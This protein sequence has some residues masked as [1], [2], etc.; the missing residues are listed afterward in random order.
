MKVAY[1]VGITVSSIL[2]LAIS[3]L[4]W[5]QYTVVQK[6][7][8]ENAN[9]SIQEVSGSLA[10][11]VSNWLDGKKSIINVLSESI[12]NNFS[13][14]YIHNIFN[15]P[16]FKDEF[17]TVFGGL[18]TDGIAIH[19]DPSWDTTGW[20]ARTRP[21]YSIAKSNIKAVLTEPYIDSDT[22]EMIISVVANFTQNG[23]YRGGFGGDLS[24]NKMSEAANTLNFGGAGYAFILSKSG[25]IISHPNKKLYDKQITELFEGVTPRLEKE[26]QLLKLKDKTIFVSFTPMTALTSVDWYIGVVLDKNK[27]MEKAVSIGWRTFVGGLISI[28]AGMILLVV[29]MK[30]ILKPL[31]HLFDS[32]VEINSGKG[33][34]TRR[35]PIKSS[36]EFGQVATEFNKFVEYLQNLINQIKELN[37][38]V[39]ISANSTSTEAEQGSK[40]LQQQL[41]ELDQLAS[42]MLEMTASANEVTNNAQQAALAAKNANQY[43][44]DGSKTVSHSSETIAQLA[45]EMDEAVQTVNEVT[46]FS[47]NIESILQVI[48]S[49]AEQ[50]NLLAL[51]AA[52]E[53]ARAG[54]SG[55]GFAVVADEVR[56]LASRTQQS[57][58][59]IRQ[60][61]EQLQS[62]VSQ[63]EQKIIKSRDKASIS[64]E[65]AQKANEALKNIH[66]SI[67]EI[68]DMNVQI[69]LASEQQSSTNE[70]IN[71]NTTN[72]R[73][74]SQDVVGTAEQQVEHCKQMIAIVNEQGD[75]LGHFKV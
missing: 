32:L 58:D 65:E 35:L 38:Q 12:D 22:G 73:D 30:K 59:E 28:I 74:I 34:L 15:R 47:T 48:A 27:V 52:I 57:T 6:S 20:D 46:R 43:A 66:Q 68:S 10:Y 21:W 42:A 7:L 60:M 24:L 4:S 14:E 50:T 40:R 64:V 62:S 54:E 9:N 19:N 67:T 75:C 56:S 33:D 51:N 36:D 29:F 44:E 13:K 26:L 2:M 71:R 45:Q 3:V 39:N 61:I 69:A 31:E 18:E 1:K 37:A 41:I 5:D 16:I 63:A 8:K 23:E 55:R 25:K 70:E 11:Q 49:I 53:A 17:I 72:I